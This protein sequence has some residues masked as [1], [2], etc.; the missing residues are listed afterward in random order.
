MFLQKEAEMKVVKIAGA[1]A[2][3]LASSAMAATGVIEWSLR[4]SNTNDL[5]MVDPLVDPYVSWTASVVV[6]GNNFGMAGFLADLGVYGPAPIAT[7][8]P[9]T[10][11]EGEFA[12]VFKAPG[13]SATGTVKDNASAGG[14]GM[15]VLPS[16]GFP[17]GA[18]AY[19]AQMQA[20]H[21]DWKARAYV[22]YTGGGTRKKWVGDDTWGVGLDSR[23]SVLL[24]DP[25]GLYDIIGGVLDV[26]TW[27]VGT[28]KV[29]WMPASTGNSVL[30]PDVNLNVDQIGNITSQDVIVTGAEFEFTIIPEPATLLLLA[31]A[32]L[33]IRRRHD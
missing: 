27:P 24:Q 6:T 19:L 8:V 28:Y 31:S 2:L 33:F 29:K 26:S 12:A 16:V 15:D 22:T 11:T 14:P 1:V 10:I 21:L 23:K 13:S 17:N 20:A 32:G 7:E 4:G 18:V 3:V 5:T 25:E 30:R 9:R